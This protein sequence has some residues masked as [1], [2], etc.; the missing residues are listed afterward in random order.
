VSASNGA[1]TVLDVHQIKFLLDIG[2]ICPF[3][4]SHLGQQSRTLEVLFTVH[5]NSLAALVNLSK[6]RQ[7]LRVAG[8]LITDKVRFA[9]NDM[10]RCSGWTPCGPYYS[11]RGVLGRR[12][13]Y[14]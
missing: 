10:A 14:R 1:R 2:R 5:H 9:D 6:P 12:I 3:P 11:K 4:A 7:T 8:L 13:K